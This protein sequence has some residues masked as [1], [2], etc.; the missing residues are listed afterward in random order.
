VADQ[1]ET[2]LIWMDE[3]ALIPGRSYYLKIGPQ[4]VSATVAEP[5]VSDQRQYD[6]TCGGQNA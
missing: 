2:T 1:F 6:G 4:T 5:K 3:E